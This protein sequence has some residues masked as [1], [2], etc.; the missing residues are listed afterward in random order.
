MVRILSKTATI[1][2]LSDERWIVLSFHGGFVE[3][4]E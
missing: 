4:L 3:H 1:E 2:W